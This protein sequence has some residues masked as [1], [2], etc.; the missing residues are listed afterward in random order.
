M[1][2]QLPSLEPPSPPAADSLSGQQLLAA[3]QGGVAWLKQHVGLLNSLNVFP[4]PDG[5]T[6]TNMH[7][8]AA[9]A[10]QGAEPDSSA[11]TVAR[12]V[13]R[14]ALMGARGNSGVILSQV[15]RGLAQGLEG[16]ERLGPRE[17]VAALDAA[18]DS[19][20]RA[21]V[22][23]VEG[24]MLTVLRDISA[25]ATDE[26]T[27]RP[28]LAALLERVVAVA[29]ETVRRTPTYLKTLRDAGVV[30]AGARG[31]HILLEGML[32][33]TRGETLTLADTPADA[34]TM[35]FHDVYDADDFG[36]CT[37]F[38]L[39]G[40]GLPYE[41]IR[42]HMAGAGRSVAVIGDESLIKVHIHT[43]RPGDILNY[44]GTR[45]TLTNIEISNMDLQRAALH[46]A[47]SDVPAPLLL[48][49]AAVLPIGVVAVAPGMGWAELFGSLNAG[50]VIGGGQAMNPSTQDLLTAIESLPQEQVVVLPNNA[51]ILLAARQAATLSRRQVAVVPARTLPQGVAALLAL[52]YNAP[53]EES[54]A[55]MEAAIGRVRTIESTT[56]ARATVLDGQQVAVGQAIALLDDVLVAAA[57]DQATAILAALGHIDLGGY[58]LLTV[59]RGAD[60]A[61]P[62]A[63]AL[64]AAVAAAFPE[65]AI[66]SREGGQPFYHYILSVE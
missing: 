31:L 29:D 51:N 6:G 55:A 65:L 50:A 35:A 56:A 44:A 62:Q 63:E 38:V 21:V 11:D 28:T 8:T 36:Y 22:K 12:Q 7:L 49:E 30:D 53:F 27:R 32:R 18:R 57:D 23:P 5:D 60:A 3:L 40:N 9:A 14:G 58:E 45:G 43:E 59:Y 16:Q 48:H 46:N 42:E 61:P 52:G 4:V 10:V 33:Q 25:A 19:A 66:E 15:L 1:T 2:T 41:E 39:L 54:L 34:P 17:L 64:I 20:Y 24:T 26:L 13:Y 47:R 37:T